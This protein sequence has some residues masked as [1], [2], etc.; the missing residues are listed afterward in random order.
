MIEIISLSFDDICMIAGGG[1][2]SCKHEIAGHEIKVMSEARYDLLYGRGVK[3]EK[4][5]G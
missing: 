5:D 2:V 3:K 4:K 1:E